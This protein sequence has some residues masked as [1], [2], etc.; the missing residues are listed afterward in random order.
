MRCSSCVLGAR[1]QTAA[2]KSNYLG[3]SELICGRCGK[4]KMNKIKT[5]STLNAGQLQRT[6]EEI[7]NAPVCRKKRMCGAQ[8]CQDTTVNHAYRMQAWGISQPAALSTWTPT[9]YYSL[10]LLREA[11]HNHFFSFLQVRNW[12][13]VQ[14]SS[15]FKVSGGNSCQGL[16]NHLAAQL[17]ETISKAHIGCQQINFP[18][19]T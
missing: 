6:G 15:L 3:P 16:C 7:L 12:G 4:K 5:H 13:R 19:A 18:K 2:T 14:P 10:L 9:L 1:A 17:G 8:K 11:T